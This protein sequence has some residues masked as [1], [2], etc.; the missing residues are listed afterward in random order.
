[1]LELNIGDKN[2]NLQNDRKDDNAQHSTDENNCSLLKEMMMSISNNGRINNN[3]TKTS[4]KSNNS[5]D[6]AT[7]NN[8]KSS[9]FSFAYKA[10]GLITNGSYSAPKSSAVFLLFINDRL[11]ESPSLRRAV[12]IRV[13]R[14]TPNGGM[15]IL[16]EGHSPQPYDLPLFLVRLANEVDWT[17]EK[18]CFKGICKE[19]GSYYSEL[20]ITDSDE[21]L[22]A[23]DDANNEL[24]EEKAKA[25]IKHTLYP[26][27]SHLLIP[28]KEFAGKG[29]MVKLASLTM[30]YK[31]FERC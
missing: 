19:I 13:C 28:P 5:N 1:M 18:P 27:I 24:V 29:S 7:T 22:Q 31:V 3:N 21:D 15:P 20:P 25:Y 9:K 2:N 14:Y 4:T 11:V 17:S 10:T 30:L 8:F 6:D 26:T 16:L 23:D 12:G